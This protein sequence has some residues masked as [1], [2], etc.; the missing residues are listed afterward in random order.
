[1]DDI[2]KKR[3]FLGSQIPLTYEMGIH[4]FIMLSRFLFIHF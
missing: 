3:V 4:F 2:N 1:M